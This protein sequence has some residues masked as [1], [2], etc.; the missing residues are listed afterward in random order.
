MTVQPIEMRLTTCRNCVPTGVVKENYALAKIT[1]PKAASVGEIRAEMALVLDCSGSMFER[2]ADDRR[3]LD[4]VIDAVQEIVNALRPND[5][6]GIVGFDDSAW[7]VAPLTAGES[8]HKLRE[9]LERL[10]NE[11]GGGTSLQPALA[12][13]VSEIRKNARDMKAARLVV[14]TD[15]QAGD[16]DATLRYVSTLERQSIASLGFGQFDFGF[17]NEVCKPSQGLCQEVGGSTPSKVKDVF[18]QELG[19][20]QNTVA[21][22]VRLR[23]RPTDVGQLLKSYIVHPNPTFIGP[24]NLGAKRELLI[25]LPVLDRTEGIEVL[26]QM[27]HP[28][29]DA[30]RFSAGEVTLLY[31]L[32]SLNLK[33][34]ELVENIEVEYVPSSDRRVS[35]LNLYVQAAFK[36]VFDEEVRLRYNEAVANGDQ[37]AADQALGT[38]MKSD[39]AQVASSATRLKVNG[40]SAEA[41]KALTTETRQKM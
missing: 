8:R 34:Q 41:F 3:H 7:L 18:L 16:A 19:V 15:G 30:G 40:H 17:M 14:L 38:L 28:L 20:A 32:P 23:V 12:L 5:R 4:A 9:A 22:N 33:D 36:R 35:D 13:A 37:A 6:L 21:S 10:R 25:D 24:A 11:G 31:D 2:G 29:R 39:N 1:V 26:L 27:R